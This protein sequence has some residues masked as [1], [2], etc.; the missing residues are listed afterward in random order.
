M[1][2]A[3]MLSDRQSY[4]TQHG[5]TGGRCPMCQMARMSH[6]YVH[7][8]IRRGIGRDLVARPHCTSCAAR[9]DASTSPRT[10]YRL[11]AGL[12]RDLFDDAEQMLYPGIAYHRLTA[13][14]RRHCYIVARTWWLD[15][16]AWRTCAK[17][18]Y[19][20]AC[21][22]VAA[23]RDTLERRGLPVMIPPNPIYA[24]DHAHH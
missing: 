4:A 16:D 17:F 6:E 9:G 13:D 19:P 2:V 11:G 22:D 23:L 3:S 24:N 12:T 10:A 1:T 20:Q 14:E 15:T 18:D 7:V 5:V 8:I 21:A